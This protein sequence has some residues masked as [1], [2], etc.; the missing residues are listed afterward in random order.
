M[1]LDWKNIDLVALLQSRVVWGSLV[2]IIASIGAITGHT[3]DAG[4]QQQI[5]VDL[6]NGAEAIATIAGVFTLHARVTA[7]PTPDDTIVPK[8]TQ[9]PGN[10]NQ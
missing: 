1:A 6:A 5:V 10:N 3:I 2:T 7:Q 9:L 8:K 4:Q